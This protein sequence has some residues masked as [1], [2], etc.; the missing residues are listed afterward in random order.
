M[1]V[2]TF[3]NWLGA[4]RPR[5]LPAAVAPVVLGSA[6][7]WSEAKFDWR[8]ALLCLCFALLAQIAANFANDYFDFL[9]G[10]DT[11]KR[12]GP[13]RAVAAGLISPQAMR[14]ATIGISITGF[15]L[16]LGLLPF[17]GWPLLVVGVLS[18]L[19]AI[20]Y[21][22]GP[23]PLAYNGLGDVFVF[24]FFGLVAVCGT[25]YVQTE[26]IGMASILG[27]ISLGGLASNLLVANN[28]RDME[29][30]REAGKRTLVVLLGRGFAKA[31]FLS[32]HLV[33]FLVPLILWSEGFDP[34]APSW[35][36]LGALS[37]WAA[38]LCAKLNPRSS[39]PELI[40]VLAGSGLYLFTYSLILSI[41][42]LDGAR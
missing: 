33:A 28:Y 31:Q 38:R 13:K 17:G 16:G 42:I 21:T 36:L 22:G 8:A 24:I 27:A 19:C 2:H 10:A 11:A 14:N 6:L 37:L 39:A 1:N 30:D 4:T 15:L 40:K 9:K 26:E 32:A 12:V 25:Y 20:A 23:F 34:S 35:I 29:T 5:T 3:K 18:I 41:W 7:A